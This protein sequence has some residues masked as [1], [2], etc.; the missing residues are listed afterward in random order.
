MRDLYI[1]IRFSLLWGEKTKKMCIFVVPKKETVNNN[2]NNQI[3]D[4]YGKRTERSRCNETSE[5]E[6]S[7]KY[8]RQDWEELWQG[9]DNE[10]RR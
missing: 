10:A 8:T 2:I 3:I 9:I 7:S 6:N 5:I 1:A 4:N